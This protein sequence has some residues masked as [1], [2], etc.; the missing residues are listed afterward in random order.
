MIFT[1]RKQKKIELVARPGGYGSAAFLSDSMRE[2]W[3]T[4]TADFL[5]KVLAGID[6]FFKRS[7]KLE[8]KNKPFSLSFAE[9]MAYF[10]WL[11]FCG[12]RSIFTRQIRSLVRWWS[13]NQRT[14]IRE[15]QKTDGDAR[16]SIRVLLISTL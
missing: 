15:Q 7:V 13:T 11:I 10:L 9:H 3:N 1:K 12:T 2:C 8:V 4:Q 5:N 6:P 14:L 16:K